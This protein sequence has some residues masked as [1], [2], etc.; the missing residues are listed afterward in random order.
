M[1]KKPWHKGSKR[2]SENIDQIDSIKI[3]GVLIRYFLYENTILG[4]Y[5]IRQFVTTYSGKYILSQY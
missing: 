1:A 5:V 3:N 2:G 4:G